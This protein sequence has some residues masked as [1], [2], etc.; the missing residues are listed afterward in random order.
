MEQTQEE[1]PQHLAERWCWP[2]A[3][4]DDVRVA[5]RL[6][7]QQVGAGVSRLDEGALLA[8]CFPCLPELGVA[9]GLTD[10]QGTTSQRVM[11]PCVHDMLLY[12]LKTVVGIE[13]RKALP[14]LLCSDAA[15]MRLVGFKAQQ[16]RQGV[17][18]RGAATRQGPRTTGPSCPEA[19]AAHIVTLRWRDREALCTGVIDALAKTGVLTAKSTGMVAA[20]DLETPAPDEGGGHVTRKRQ[21]PDT[22]GKGHA[23]EVTV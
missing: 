4:R 18:Q 9:D 1:M 22:R 8:A 7:H 3:R 19:W 16:V 20:T 5:R 11:V 2:A 12:R 6:D 14:A 17:C 15:L 10:V 23:S 21:L 13:R